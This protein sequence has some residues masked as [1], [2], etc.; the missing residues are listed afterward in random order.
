MCGSLF[1]VFATSLTELVNSAAV[2]AKFVETIQSS[3][4]LWTTILAWVTNDLTKVP[5]SKMRWNISL[6]NDSDSSVRRV[7]RQT[8]K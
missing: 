1:D 4:A 3:N 2:L 8:A 5:S 6:T 7:A